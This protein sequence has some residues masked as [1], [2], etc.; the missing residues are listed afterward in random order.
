MEAKLFAKVY[1]LVFGIAHPPG[2]R[3]QFCDQWIVLIYLWSVLHDRSVLWACDA[4]NWP[5]RMEASLPA[6][7]TMSRRLRTVGV[8][9]LLDRAMTL[10]GDLFGP[11]LVKTLDSKPLFVGAYSKDRDARRGRTGAGMMARGY[12]LHSLNYG[13]V[14]RAWTLGTMNAHDSVGGATPPGAAVGRGRVRGGR[15]R[16]RR[17]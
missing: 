13:R 7:S 15:Q 10:A 2:K 6:D 9:Q 8:L 3:Q 4:R 1:R 5:A 11:G 16:V 14:V 12:R 17:Q